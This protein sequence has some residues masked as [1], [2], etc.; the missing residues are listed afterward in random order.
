M[1]MWL[2]KTEFI[3]AQDETHEM[4]K[5]MVQLE[6][7]TKPWAFNP[8]TATPKRGALPQSPNGSSSGYLRN[9][10]QFWW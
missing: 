7:D 5:G 10:R 1:V 9:F 3:T 2:L 4:E 6:I 8:S